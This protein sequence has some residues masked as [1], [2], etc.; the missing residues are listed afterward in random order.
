[1]LVPLSSVI[2]GASGV[3]PPHITA[4][5]QS[6]GPGGSAAPHFASTVPS[7]PVMPAPSAGQLLQQAAVNQ[8]LQQ[9]AAASPPSA[10]Y[11]QAGLNAVS[12]TGRGRLGG[13]YQG[14]GG[15]TSLAALVPHVPSPLHAAAAKSEAPA[16][17]AGTACSV[18]SYH[19]FVNNVAAIKVTKLL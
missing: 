11:A 18:N 2:A 16:A 9:Q 17:S 7:A 8:I 13:G 1:M 10:S 5:L 14:A 19:T 3:L 12:A 4:A 6:L 15:L